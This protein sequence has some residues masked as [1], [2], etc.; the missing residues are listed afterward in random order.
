MQE[1]KIIQFPVRKNAQTEDVAAERA[2][3]MWDY[4]LAELEV[5]IPKAEPTSAPA[6]QV[7]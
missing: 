3:L 4:E 5:T 2:M 6:R 1:K 7:Y